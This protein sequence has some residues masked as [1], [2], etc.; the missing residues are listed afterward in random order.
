MD[1]VAVARGVVGVRRVGHGGTLDPMATGLL[2]VLIGAATKFMGR[3]QEAP[4]VYAAVVRFGSET[5]TDDAEGQT[6]VTSAA[7][8]HL[9][10]ERALAAFRGVISQ[11]PPAYAA[12]KVDGR[13]AYDRARAGETLEL[14]AREVQVHRLDVTEWK[15]GTDLGL[16]VVCSSGTYVRSLARD[17]GRSV[18]SSAHLAALRRLAIGALE[19]RDAIGIEALRAAGTDA[20]LARIRPASDGL[21]ALDPRYLREPADRLAG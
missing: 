5:A 15:S 7:P 14:A 20:A 21:L 2:A 17:L 10:V 9:D 18:G 13:R 8:A 12:V 3:L 4:K 11:R 6:T 1:V 19:V 16:L